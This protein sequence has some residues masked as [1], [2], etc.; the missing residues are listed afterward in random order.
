MAEVQVSQG[1]LQGE[2]S[3]LVTGDGQYY[4]FKGIPYAAPPL[5]D[6]RF[7][8]GKNIV[9]M[10]IFNMRLVEINYLGSISEF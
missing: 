3:N 2:V 8:V 5:G 6:L 9:N 7:K 10:S 4:S 1:W